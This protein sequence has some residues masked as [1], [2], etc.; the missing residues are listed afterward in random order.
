[1]KGLWYYK[2]KYNLEM[3]IQKT[4]IIKQNFSRKNIFKQTMT[5]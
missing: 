1:M 3:Q 2:N 4:N 5:A